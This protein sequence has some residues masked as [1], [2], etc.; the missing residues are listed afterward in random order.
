MRALPKAPTRPGYALC[1]SDQVTGLTIV[2]YISREERSPSGGRLRKPS[3]SASS[4]RP[5]M[6]GISA[7]FAGRSCPTVNGRTGTG[8]I[9]TSLNPWKRV[10]GK[11]KLVVSN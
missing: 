11:K 8:P 6:F 10:T 3:P 2:R 5:A 4:R 1:P 9:R 7:S